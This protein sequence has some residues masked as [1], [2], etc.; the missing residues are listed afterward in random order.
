MVHPR[1]GKRGPRTARK[2][3]TASGRRER[4]RPGEPATR[5][6][7][8]SRPG[9][10]RFG[11][12]RLQRES[13]QSLIVVT[14]TMLVIMLVS[15]LALDVAMW[16]QRHHQAQLAA[17][18]AA[19]AAANCLANSGTGQTC[20]ST[21]D[22]TDAIAVA[23]TF[24]R[25]N[26]VSIPASDVTF[27]NVTNPSTVTVT[28][29]EP[30]PVLFG[31][32]AGIR[33]AATSARAAAVW[34]VGSGN[35]TTTM[36]NQNDCYAIFAMDQS[37]S[38]NGVLFQGGGYHIHGGVH[39]NSSINTGGGGSSYGPTT[40]GPTGSA[41]T[42]AT[43][44]GDSFTSGPTSEAPITTWPINYTVD[45]PAC[46]GSGCT[47]PNGTPS[48]CSASAAS[49]SFTSQ[50]MPTNGYI[51]CAYGTG[52]KGEP[53]TWNGTI[54]FPWGSVGSQ[55]NPIVATLV[56]GNV[57]TGSGSNF[58][59]AC[60]YALSGFLASSCKGASG[61]TV[62]TPLTTNYPAIYAV[63][64]NSQAGSSNGDAPVYLGGGGNGFTGDVFAPN[65]L[66]TIAAGSISTGFLEGWDV[67]LTAGGI[68]GDGPSATGDAST[69]GTDSL[70]Q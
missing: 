44:G 50:S 69:G 60:G 7:L 24:A 46:S 62:P 23:T 65:G 31:G 17:D 27:N 25:S 59:K 56:A 32:I 13:G 61:Q 39:S 68:T 8:R 55:G 47:G 52:T 35:C 26:G 67:S 16:Y 28:T 42:K 9:A 30:A 40:Y 70:V 63:D 1:R 4:D 58:I 48:F 29:P 38:N 51:Y 21:T 43:G 37:C 22:T 36:Q 54:S 20:T 41:C 14:L 57:Y 11:P 66:L 45:F 49:Y 15:A 3:P 64:T 12:A 18:A 6:T 10:G 2:A 34:K 19:L 5:I 53:S 33:T